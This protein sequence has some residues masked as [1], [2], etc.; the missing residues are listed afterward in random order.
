MAPEVMP[1]AASATAR[2]A[3]GRI[4]RAPLRR[5]GAPRLRGSAVRFDAEQELEDFHPHPHGHSLVATAHGKLLELV[6]LWEGPVFQRGATEE[7]RY[8]G[9]CYLHSGRIA[10]ASCENGEWRLRLFDGGGGGGGG[11]VGGGGLGV[12]L[13]AR[14][15]DAP[16]GEPWELSPSPVADLLA[17]CTH[18]LRLL[19]A[20]F[21]RGGLV[22]VDA[23]SCDGG[24]FDVAWSA[25]GSWLAYAVATSPSARTA[26]IRLCHVESGRRVSLSS[27]HFRDTSPAWDPAGRFVAFVSSRSLRAVEDEIFWAMGF[28]RAQRAYLVPLT[29]ATAD[30]CLA[31]P[32]PPGWQPEDDESGSE[33]GEEQHASPV[34]VEEEGLQQRL[35]PLPIPPSRLGRLAVSLTRPIFPIRHAPYFPICHTRGFIFRC[36]GMIW[37]STCSCLSLAAPTRMSAR[38]R[39]ARGAARR[40]ST[41]RRSGVRSCDSPSAAAAFN[42]SSSSK[43]S[44]SLR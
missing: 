5:L 39:R 15:T 36:S 13:R 38:R 30:P 16:L 1:G 42:R 43:T 18:D 25:C 10:A 20:D 23:S 31:P 37:S 2:A 21:T 7:V 4:Y 41:M 35:R 3:L 33:D 19:I 11:G 34:R 22:E 17:V 9:G 27:G 26:A 24:I 12:P 44:S 14:P 32:R 28:A 29:A 40:A 8:S 6:G